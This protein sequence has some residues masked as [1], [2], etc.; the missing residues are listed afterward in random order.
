MVEPAKGNGTKST[1]S[2][3]L[4]RN[5]GTLGKI[6]EQKDCKLFNKLDGEAEIQCKVCC[7][8]PQF[9]RANK[10]FALYHSL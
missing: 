8:V 4:L 2:C 5:T 7:I 1:I 10:V 3:G 9:I 6:V